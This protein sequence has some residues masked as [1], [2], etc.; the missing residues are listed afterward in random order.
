M[1]GFS[2]QFQGGFAGQ[3]CHVEFNNKDDVITESFYPEDINLVQNFN[4]KNPVLSN[5]IK[6]VF[7]KSTDFFGRIVVYSLDIYY[8]KNNFNNS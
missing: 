2:I 3:N 6:L 7:D 4:F 5:N 8:D 1:T